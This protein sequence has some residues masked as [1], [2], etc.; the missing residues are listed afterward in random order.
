MNIFNDYWLKPLD[1][2]NKIILGVGRR[3]TQYAVKAL[4]LQPSVVEIVLRAALR[5][6][7]GR[8]LITSIA[9]LFT[10]DDIAMSS[11]KLDN[12]TDI[13]TQ[14]CKKLNSPPPLSKSTRE[15]LNQVN[16]TNVLGQTVE[17][18]TLNAC[19]T[20]NDF[21]D[22]KFSSYEARTPRGMD[23]VIFGMIQLHKSNPTLEEIMQELNETYERGATLHEH[24]PTP[25]SLD[26]TY[27]PQFDL[28]GGLT[29]GFAA[30]TDRMEFIASPDRN[31]VMMNFGLVQTDPK[32]EV[33]GDV[34][35]LFING[36]PVALYDINVNINA[37]G[38]RTGDRVVK[39]LLEASNNGIINI[40]NIIPSARTFWERLG[41]FTPNIGDGDAY[42]YTLKKATFGTSP[43]GRALASKEGNVLR[44]A[45][46][47]FE[48][49]S[50]PNIR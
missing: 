37:R 39:A 14:L 43:A 12:I 18:W 15:F 47:T 50:G 6:G 21:K 31:E 24:T 20:L 35:V 10:T 3:M 44:G 25:I 5:E 26:E 33:L 17:D 45:C 46:D 40:S 28:G 9:N 19:K 8:T 32:F 27:Q 2:Q 41:T 4:A 34:D 13:T 7:R 16:A 11:V 38:N 49:E 1:E 42:D 22:E 29:M 36:K 48:S 30:P 23:N